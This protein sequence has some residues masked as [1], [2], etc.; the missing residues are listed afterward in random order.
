MILIAL[1][2]A[3]ALA[4]VLCTWRHVRAMHLRYGNVDCVG[5]DID[6]SA[7]WCMTMAIEMRISHH[8]GDRFRSRNDDLQTLFL[9]PTPFDHDIA[10]PGCISPCRALSTCPLAL[11]RFS[12]YPPP[13]LPYLVLVIAVSARIGAS[14]DLLTMPVVQR[15][16]LF[17]P[18]SC[19]WQKSASFVYLGRC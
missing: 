18:L 16:K 6:M 14:A 12:R 19:I 9:P 8:D 7:T 13:H 1:H 10:G 4:P 17:L 2:F 5:Q 11:V 15:R 3:R